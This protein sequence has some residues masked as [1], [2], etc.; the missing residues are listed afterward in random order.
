ME[1]FIT[2]DRGTDYLFPPSMQNWPPKDHLAHFVGYPSGCLG[3]YL[4]NT[5]ISVNR[6]ATCYALVRI[7]PDREYKQSASR[8]TKH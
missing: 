8:D 4:G 5:S 6:R 3:K 1:N 7:T 2:A